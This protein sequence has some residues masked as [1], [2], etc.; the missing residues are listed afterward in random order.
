[1]AGSCRGAWRRCSGARKRRG[2]G[3]GGSLAHQEV[4]GGVGSAEGAPT[5]AESTAAAVVI[6]GG[7][8]DGVGDSRHLGSIPSARNKR[9]TRRSFSAH[10]WRLG[11]R[12]T[13]A[14]PSSQGGG[15]GVLGG[16]RGSE[17]G[18]EREG[19]GGPWRP[20]A[21]PGSH[22][23]LQQQAGGGTPVTMRRTRRCADYWKKKKGRFCR[24]PPRVW[25]IPGQN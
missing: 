21:A 18:R 22:L 9:R 20:G 3:P 23:G 4:A 13:A 12:G 15:A 14:L 17:P 8:S 10:R 6:C 19:R 2:R 24:K 5:V 7:I 25:K 1:M 11:Q 16:G